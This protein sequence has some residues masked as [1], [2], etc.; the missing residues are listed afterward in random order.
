[1][2]VIGHDDVARL[3]DADGWIAV[4]ALTVSNYNGSRPPLAPVVAPDR[5]QPTPK[6]DMPGP[7]AQNR[8]HSPAR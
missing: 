5:V 3:S 4:V 8:E 1:L 2:V 6:A 7:P